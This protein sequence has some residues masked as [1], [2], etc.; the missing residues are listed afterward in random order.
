V[1]ERLL[2]PSRHGAGPNVSASPSYAGACSAKAAQSDGLD[3]SRYRRGSIVVPA[4]NEAA[5]LEGAVLDILSAARDL[6]E[7]YEILIVNDGSTDGTGAVADRLAEQH[8][9]IRVLH[10]DR[11]RGIAAAYIRALDEAKLDYFSFLPGDGEIT[12]QSIRNILASIGRA[13]VVIPYHANS[14]ARPWHRRVLTRSSTTLVNLLFGLHLRYFQG[15]CIYP[16]SLARA[17]PKTTNGFYFLTEMLVNA[18]LAGHSYVEVGLT[19][20][21]R[22]SGRSKAV[23]FAN[24]LRALTAILTIWWRARV[25]NHFARA[26][27]CE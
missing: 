2:R 1:I 13:T 27:R 25:R 14:A 12:V 22:G 24:I 4:Y 11:N 16:I 10:H 3:R 17:L 5:N 8:P 7:D 21:E 20:Q 15:P 18:L 9:K 19:H 6:L 23:S 26:E